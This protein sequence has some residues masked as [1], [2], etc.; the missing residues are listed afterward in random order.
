MAKRSI[1]EIEDAVL[2]ALSPLADSLGVR[3]IESYNGEL[4]LEKIEAAV[5]Q[6]PAVLV[7]YA[8]SSVEKEGRRRNEHL[9]FLCF[10]CDRHESEQSEAR[11]GGLTNP[12]TYALL[13]GVADLLE[14]KRQIAADDVF[15]AD[16]L[17]QQT[18]VQGHALSIY[19]ARY[20]IQTVYLVP[21]E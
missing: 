18:E 4:D 13:D 20:S 15:P 7:Y 17:A 9:A 8:G 10:C 12:G 11:R 14:G 16:R 5:Q 21:M 19:S 2:A 3:Q 6:W 1:K